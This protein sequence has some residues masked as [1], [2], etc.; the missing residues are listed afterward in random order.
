MASNIFTVKNLSFSYGKQQVLNGLDFSLHEGR[1]T[2]LI[3]AN[4]CGKS[5]LGRTLIRMYEPTDGT[6]IYDGDDITKIKF[7]YT[8]SYR[9]SSKGFWTTTQNPD[10]VQPLV[11]VEKQETPL[12]GEKEVGV[13]KREFDLSLRKFISEVNGKEINTM[14]KHT[15]N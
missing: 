11:A 10:T 6:L 14:E 8:G 9:T 1:I 13:A 2:T 4:G 3:G 7:S 12:S 5:T 15:S